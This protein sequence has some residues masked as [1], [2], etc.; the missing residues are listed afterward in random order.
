[1]ARASEAV[2]VRW[3]T[4]FLLWAGLVLGCGGDRPEEAAGD[5]ADREGAGNRDAVLRG[6]QL[7]ERHGCAQCHGPE[8]RADGPLAQSLDPPP[9]DLQDPG[10]YLRGHE[11]D[12]IEES[13]R[14]G[15]RSGGRK[16]PA[17]GHLTEEDRRSMAVYIHSLLES[18]D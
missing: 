16:M 14:K 1:M 13:I 2:P 8:G 15:V 4:G 12:Q 11:V 6:R 18:R 9:R 5:P 17:Y 7:Y 10:Q 3:P